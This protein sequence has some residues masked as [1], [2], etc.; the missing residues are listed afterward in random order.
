MVSEQSIEWNGQ[1]TPRIVP[2]HLPSEDEPLDLSTSSARRVDVAPAEG[3]DTA[4]RLVRYLHNEG[5]TVQRER[6]LGRVIDARPETDVHAEPPTEATSAAANATS[7]RAASPS[8]AAEA[9]VFADGPELVAQIVEPSEANSAESTFGA[10]RVSHED[11][12]A[13][14]PTPR[15]APTS[16]ASSRDALGGE[17]SDRV[18]GASVVPVAVRAPR[19]RANVEAPVAEPRVAPTNEPHTG[20]ADVRAADEAPIVANR[21]STSERVPSATAD[22]ARIDAPAANAAPY[23]DDVDVAPTRLYEV[24]DARGQSAPAR[25]SDVTEA[26]RAARPSHDVAAT[27]RAATETRGATD[28]GADVPVEANARGAEVADTPREGDA[29]ARGAEV[30]DAP[31]GA[32]NRDGTTA[33]VVATTNPDDGSD[34][35][36]SRMSAPANP[37]AAGARRDHGAAQHEV[38]ARGVAHADGPRAPTAAAGTD[39]DTAHREASTMNDVERREGATARDTSVDAAAPEATD[40][41]EAPSGEA[42]ERGDR[43]TG[44]ARDAEAPLR[45]APVIRGAEAQRGFAAQAVRAEETVRANRTEHAVRSGH[46]AHSDRTVR[47]VRADTHSADSAAREDTSAPAPRAPRPSAPGADVA[48]VGSERDAPKTLRADAPWFT[49]TTTPSATFAAAAPTP[50][51]TPDARVAPEAVVAPNAT[52]TSKTTVAPI[53]PIAAEPVDAEPLADAPEPEALESAD[54][55]ESTSASER[56]SVDASMNASA[57]PQSQSDGPPAR[58]PNPGP[59]A[60]F[61][62]NDATKPFDVARGED[63]PAF[64]AERVDAQLRSDPARP[65]EQVARAHRLFEEAQAIARRQASSNYRRFTIDL[66]AERGAPVRLTITPDHRGH[67]H[68]A[69]VAATHAARAELERH[70]HELE[71]IVEAFPLDVSGLTIDARPSARQERR[72]F[73][74]RISNHGNQRPERR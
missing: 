64:V 39:G 16:A 38:K 19:A 1:L 23:G 5:I 14:A 2:E 3:D 27:N 30:A 70:R 4:M 72:A 42:P 51:P 50:R 69:L 6:A 18:Q 66:P 73:D 57:D 29:L 71:E 32:T 22:A 56:E 41:D 45:E 63:T 40:V 55:A 53:T 43:S 25:E 36:P 37:R 33:H 10:D 28:H 35:A 74:E 59:H 62:P 49:A 68:V 46:A 17:P 20:S 11:A 15:A 60:A 26:P 21:A 8:P 67:H 31:V 47:G 54:R 52:F 24:A 9:R 48:A 65:T 44:A 34:E 12:R 58:D 13:N 61:D 7:P